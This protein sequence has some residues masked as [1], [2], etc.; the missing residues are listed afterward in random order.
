VNVTILSD[1]TRYTL[2]DMSTSLHTFTPCLMKLHGV[3]CYKAV[4]FTITVLSFITSDIV[5][6]V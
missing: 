5:K 1:M 3:I 2:V 6:C 4:T